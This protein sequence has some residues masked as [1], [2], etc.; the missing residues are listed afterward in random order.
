MPAP[1][2]T[3]HTAPTGDSSPPLH[4]SAGCGAESYTT[5]TFSLSHGGLERTFRVF[6]PSTHDPAVPAPLVLAFHG[7]A[8]D[9]N[10]FLGSAAVRDASEA[11]G[12][13][14]VAPRGLGSGPP[15]HAWASWAFPG[16]TTGLDGDGG[17]ICDPSQTG[18]YR[19]DSCAGVAQNSCSWTHCQA[20]DVDFVL[21]LLDELEAGLCIDT[22]AVAAAGGSNG[23]MFTWSLAQDPR[24][25]PRLHAI[26][27][28][29]GLPHRGYLGGPATPSLPA[30]LMTG[31]RDRTVPPGDWDDP[32][33]TVTTDGDRYY[34]T[35]ATAITR[36][37]AGAH[38]C[39]PSLPA[40]R[41]DVGIPDLD[42]RSTC[43]SPSSWPPVL[44]CRADMGH[45]YDLGT[46][47]PL[48]LDFVAAHR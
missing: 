27:P 10:E 35:G 47:W 17:A 32:A 18:D 31:T 14:V 1:P 2:S 36:V 19:Y 43:D 8:G 25:A 44:D 6:V 9:E 48:V 12:I 24:S 41:V 13:I 11:H 45:T 22:R 5:G 4:A 38:G 26:A 28:L 37:W 33:P 3:G 21:A 29:I 23:G 16:S 42:C 7:W 30:L 34:Y 39:D 46:T 40:S 15:D 20:D